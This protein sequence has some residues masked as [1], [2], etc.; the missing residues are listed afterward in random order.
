MKV[1][2]KKAFKDYDYFFVTKK[3]NKKADILCIKFSSTFGVSVQ[4]WLFPYFKIIAPIF[5]CFI[6][7]EECLNPQ[8]RIY[9]ILNEHITLVLQNFLQGYTLL[10]FN[11][12]LRS[13]SL[14]NV[15]WVFSQTCIPQWKNYWKIPLW[16]KELNLFI[17]TLAPK[18][19]SLPR[20]Y[21]QYSRQK[22]ITHFLKT[23]VFKNLFFPQQRGRGL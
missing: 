10:H 19:N 7:F 18:Q 23:N 12:L 6:F 8:V 13:L 20:F 4:R 2:I 15:S 16:V 17:F 3:N 21:N 5:C 22:A 14:Q 11:R 9:K 1:Q